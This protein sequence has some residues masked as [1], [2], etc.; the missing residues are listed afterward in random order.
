MDKPVPFSHDK[1]CNSWCDHPIHAI[2]VV[3]DLEATEL[4]VQEFVEWEGLIFLSAKRDVEMDADRVKKTLT[5]RRDPRTKELQW[6]CWADDEPAMVW[7]A[8]IQVPDDWEFIIPEKRA[9]S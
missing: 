6:D 4:E 8:R 1:G 3:T 7:Y 5:V 2:L 9:C